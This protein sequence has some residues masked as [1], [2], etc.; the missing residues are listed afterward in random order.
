MQVGAGLPGSKYIYGAWLICAVSLRYNWFSQL[1]EVISQPL[2]SG[3]FGDF[4]I[5][6]L[7]SG[8]TFAALTVGL[9]GSISIWADIC[10]RNSLFTIGALIIIVLGVVTAGDIIAALV[11]D[12]DPFITKSLLNFVRNPLSLEDLFRYGLNA[13]LSVNMTNLSG[14]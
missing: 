10:S 14:V 13:S 7:L 12:T 1:S 4:T 8:L 5:F 3:G 6:S 9:K 2:F 11:L